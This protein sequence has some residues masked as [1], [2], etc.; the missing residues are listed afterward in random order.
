[1]L[2][3]LLL[4]VSW[5]MFIG[6]CQADDSM[7]V[8][9]AGC[10]FSIPSNPSV[11][12]TSG[13]ND[14]VNILMFKYDDPEKSGYITLMNM[15]SDPMLEEMLDVRGCDFATFIEDLITRN[16]DTTCNR[17]PLEAFY[18]D[19]EN[20]DFG[21]WDG[22]D[23][24]KWLYMVDMEKSFIYLIAPDE[25]VIQVTTNLLSGEKELKTIIDHHLQ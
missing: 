14:H 10:D 1:M 17:E 24:R 7:L 13:E 8:T 22:K 11:V 9:Y 21:S 15:S 12:A 16:E 6:T 20:S 3:R 18:E 2:S 5:M 25:K 4:I 19:L 23:E